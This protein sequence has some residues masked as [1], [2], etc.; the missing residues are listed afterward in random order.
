M[1]SPVSDLKSSGD[2]Y[3]ITG[4]FICLKWTH[5]DKNIKHFLL[6]TDVQSSVYTQ[7]T[8]APGSLTL[9]DLLSLQGETKIGF[10]AYGKIG[11]MANFQVMG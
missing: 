7:K 11:F 6:W 9:P 4:T 1:I 3:Q 5:T 10:L 8:R 2:Y